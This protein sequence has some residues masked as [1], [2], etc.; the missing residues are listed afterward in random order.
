MEQENIKIIDRFI[1]ENGYEFL[2]NFYPS[3]IRFDGLLY[4]TV[5]HAYQASKTIDQNLRKIIS[6][7]SN[8]IETKKIGKTLKLRENWEEIKVDIMKN[9]IREK[10]HNPFLGYLL[11]K[12]GN[13]KLIMK[14]FW[15][16]K[17]WGIYNGI[18]ENWLGRILE[19]VRAEVQVEFKELIEND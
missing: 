1:K 2:S 16:D 8:P 5:E 4:P 6:K 17:F 19:E 12:T 14:N 7:I 13:N 18:G 3:I 11:I 10:F 15:N 9:L